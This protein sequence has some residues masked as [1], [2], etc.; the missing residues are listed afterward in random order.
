MLLALSLLVN[1]SVHGEDLLLNGQCSQ[2]SLVGDSLLDT[3]TKRVAI[4]GRSPPLMC[5]RT[6]HHDVQERARRVRLQPTI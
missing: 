1:Q 2:K 3:G 5:M 4:I 6:A